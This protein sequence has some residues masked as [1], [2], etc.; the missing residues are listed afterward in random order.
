MEKQKQK[1]GDRDEF[2]DLMVKKAFSQDPKAEPY[3]PKITTSKDPELKPH[4]ESVN[5]EEIE[6]LTE[7]LKSGLIKKK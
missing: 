1:K 5:V 2:V 3:T 4:H 6:Q 7:K